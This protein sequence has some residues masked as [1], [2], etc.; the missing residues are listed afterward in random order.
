MAR[1]LLEFDEALERDNYIQ[2]VAREHMLPYE[3]LRRLV[4]RLGNRPGAVT[5]TAGRQQREESRESKGRRKR[6]TE[7][8]G[9]RGFC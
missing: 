2:A 8:A 6:M 7:T 4:N 9:L 3:D 1:K 5:G